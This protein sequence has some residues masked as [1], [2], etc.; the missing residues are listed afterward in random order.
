MLICQR[1]IADE[2]LVNCD[3]LGVQVRVP[4]TGQAAPSVTAA[5][6]LGLR[7]LRQLSLWGLGAMKGGTAVR[8]KKLRQEHNTR[9]MH[10]NCQWKNAN[11]GS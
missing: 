10:G 8:N 6:K 4:S 3:G 7:V 1:V 2:P 11:L 9:S 5:S